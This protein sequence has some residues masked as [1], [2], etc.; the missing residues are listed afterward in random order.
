VERAGGGTTLCLIPAKFN[1]KLWFKRGGFLLIEEAPEAAADAASRVTGTILNVLYEEQIRQLKRTPGAWPPEFEAAAAAAPP[2]AADGDAYAGLPAY[3]DDSGSEEG[4]SGGGGEEAAARPDA[5]AASAS[6][7][8]GA[9]AAAAGLAAAR[10]ADADDGGSESGG[11]SSGG[12]D[13]RPP[14]ERIANR[15]VIHHDYSSDSDEDG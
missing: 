4:G 1:K 6:G 13:G 10:I 2:A 5:G 8:G 14:L 9:D 3:S 12:D 7:G 11:S 15:R